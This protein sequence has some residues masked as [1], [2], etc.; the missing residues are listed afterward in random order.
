MERRDDGQ[1]TSRDKK[2]YMAPTVTNL[3]DVVE[4]TMG[5]PMGDT[6]EC[7]GMLAWTEGGGS[8]V[9]GGGGDGG[10]VPSDGKPGKNTKKT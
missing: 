3:G 6:M 10:R 9:G 1:T 4:Q 8:G 2:P 7:H 5:E